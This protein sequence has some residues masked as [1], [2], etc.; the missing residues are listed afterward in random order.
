MTALEKYNARARAANSLLCVGLDPEFEKLPERFRAVENPQF[1]FNKEIINATHPHAA[2]YKLNIAFYEA[3]GAAGFKDLK[4]TTDYLRENHPEIL[5]LCD[6]KRNEVLNTSK[7]YATALFDHFGF[8]GTTLN[9]YLGGE[10]LQPFLER[11]DKACIVLCRTSNPGAS[12][13]QD[14]KVDDSPLWQVIL[15]K[16]RD[17]WNR[18]GNC[19]L[20]LGATFPDE[21]AVAR[22]LAGEMTFLVPG[23]GA[24]GGDTEA[25][26]KAGLNSEGLGLI[27]NSSRGIILA[28]DPGVEAQKLKDLINSF[29]QQ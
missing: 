18:N 5:L 29:R 12:E 6:A 3:R 11:K 26:I 17:E 19:M 8:D 16:V 15:K 2:A 28:P 1:E 13:I 22:R 7:A 24:Q 27:V 20:V 21:L 10:P 14:L 9:P 23:L 25:T 4:L